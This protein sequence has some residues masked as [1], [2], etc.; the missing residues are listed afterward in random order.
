MMN[1][2]PTTYP[3]SD[4]TYGSDN[5]PAPIAEEQRAK[6]LPLI[7]PA[8]IFVNVLSLN[9]LLWLEFGD[10]SDGLIGYVKLGSIL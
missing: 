1:M 2:I 10:K 3:H 7:L 6:I 9:V 4:S 5:T 8:Y